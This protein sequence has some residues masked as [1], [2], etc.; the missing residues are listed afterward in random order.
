[1]VDLFCPSDGQT[2]ILTDVQ[3]DRLT[4]GQTGRWTDGQTGRRRRT[5][6]FIIK[7][8]IQFNILLHQVSEAVDKNY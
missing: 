7:I 8:L 1:M 4:G 3:T 6:L 5:A 2:D